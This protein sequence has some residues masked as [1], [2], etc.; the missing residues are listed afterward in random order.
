M[1]FITGQDTTRDLTMLVI[2]VEYCKGSTNK[3]T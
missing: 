1:T 3:V 2:L